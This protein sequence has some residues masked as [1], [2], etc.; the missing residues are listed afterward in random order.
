VV[1]RALAA[2][3]VL[4]LCGASAV[5][6]QQSESGECR[7]EVGQSKS[8]AG[9]CIFREGR[10]ASGEPLRG[11]RAGAPSLQGQPAA[12]VQC[13]RRS[14]LGMVEGT[15]VIPPISGQFLFRPGQRISRD[16]PMHEGASHLLPTPPDRLAYDDT[17]LA[18][19]I[20]DGVG[21]D[22]RALNYL[23]PRYDLDDASMGALIGYLRDLSPRRVPGVSDPTLHFATIVT[24][25]ADPVARDGMLNVLEQYFAE[26]NG[27]YIGENA[28]PLLQDGRPVALRTQRRWQLHVW[29]LTGVPES[30]E[31]QLDQHLRAE[32]VFA[33]I[34]GLAGSTWEPVHHFC[35]RQALP[36]LLPNVE[37]P[38]V[39]PDEFYSVYFSQGVL[40]EAQLVAARLGPSP[41]APLPQA[42]EG[43]SSAAGGRIVQVFRQD[44]IGAAA[45]ARLHAA[46]G[47]TAEFADL[48]LARGD[49]PHKLAQAVEH[50]KK[51]D[52][53]VLW[54]RAPDLAALPEPAAGTSTAYVSGLMGGLEHVP[55]SPAW[56]SIARM[57]YPYELPQARSLRLNYPLGWFHL[58]KIPVVDERVQVDTYVA[59]SVLLETLA[60]MLDEFVRDFLVERVEVMLDARLINGYYTRLGLAP[61]QRFAS[62]GGYLVRFGGPA[63]VQMAADGGWIVP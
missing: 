26:K 53:L 49:G 55:L 1:V 11:E 7:A 20:R 5:P 6:T 47:G 32:P 39:E 63:G 19:A 45:A 50:A 62:K 24:S 60:S 34:S 33:V 36:C 3:A 10:L 59:C 56:R 44:D 51:G 40:L 46:L 28:S 16:S 2:T 15:I 12:C 17:T 14:G 61:G 8:E 13:H 23:M 25:D 37:L 29:R 41:S 9:E 35:E 4:I 54:L 21:P 48:P 31:A 52:T 43:R 42:G 38:V 30:W 22:G 27:H 58:R 18:R 57:T